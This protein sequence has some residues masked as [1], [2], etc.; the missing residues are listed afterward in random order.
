[1]QDSYVNN[2]ADSIEKPTMEAASSAKDAPNLSASALTENFD[3]SGCPSAL[4]S[5]DSFKSCM[6]S[7]DNVIVDDSRQSV[8]VSDNG[9]VEVPKE[10]GAKELI[11]VSTT[12]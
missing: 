4:T 1:M 10:N 7:F 9:A 6:S 11:H 12:N 5:T 8:E 3:Q 2:N